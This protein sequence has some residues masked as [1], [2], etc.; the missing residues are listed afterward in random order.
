MPARCARERRA[1][2]SQGSAAPGLRP[3]R[4]L[5]SVLAAASARPPPWGSLFS[6]LRRKSNQKK[7]KH[8]FACGASRRA[9]LHRSPKR[10]TPPAVKARPFGRAARGL[11]GVGAAG[12][13]RNTVSLTGGFVLHRTQ[14]NTERW[15]ALGALSACVGAPGH[16]KHPRNTVARLRLD[17]ATVMHAGPV[18]PGLPSACGRRQTRR[19]IG[20]GAKRTLADCASSSKRASGQKIAGTG[21]RQERTG[22]SALPRLELVGLDNGV[23]VGCLQLVGGRNEPDGAA[24]CG[25]SADRRAGRWKHRK[26]SPGC[27][28]R[29]DGVGV[30]WQAERAGRRYWWRDGLDACR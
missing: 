22:C 5:R 30:C 17:Q 23:R 8:G 9:V 12:H 11:D 29:W 20:M 14:K 2:P 15:P 16:E 19:E 7:A 3:L 10:R 13:P 28:G 1:P 26:R 27:S 4:V 24:H 18:P 6:R 21:T 25:R